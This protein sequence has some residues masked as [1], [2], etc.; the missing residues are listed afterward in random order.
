MSL[1][2]FIWFYMI[3][4]DFL[5]FY[6][7]SRRLPIGGGPGWIFGVI[8]YLIWF[9]LILIDFVWFYISL[10]EFIWVYMILYEFIWVYMSLYEFIWVDM[11]WYELMQVYK[12]LYD[13]LWF[14]MILFDFILFYLG[15]LEVARR[16]RGPQGSGATEA[17]MASVE[18]KIEYLIFGLI[19]Y[20]FEFILFQKAVGCKGRWDSKYLILFLRKPKYQHATLPLYHCPGSFQL[21]KII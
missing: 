7:G 15:K 12:S 21:P 3:L 9:Y 1:Y 2:E 6:F 19:L 4:F 8:S 5:R 11:G 16:E 18:V 10:Y 13:F 17:T 20:D 14:Y